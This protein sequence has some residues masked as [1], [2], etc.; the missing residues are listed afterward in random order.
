MHNISCWLVKEE[1]VLDRLALALHR[2]GALH[3]LEYQVFD[4][5]TG[6]GG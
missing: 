3:Q 2:C 4:M 1:E 5:E 6:P